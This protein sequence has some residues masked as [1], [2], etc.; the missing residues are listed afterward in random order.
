MLPVRRAEIKKERDRDQWSDLYKQTFDLLVQGRGEAL[1]EGIY[2]GAAYAQPPFFEF[3]AFRSGEQVQRPR[4]IGW[5]HPGAEIKKAPSGNTGQIDGW[6]ADGS[7]EHQWMW[8]DPEIVVWDQW[9]TESYQKISFEQNE[10]STSNDPRDWIFH[11]NWWVQQPNNNRWVITDEK[12]H[13]SQRGPRGQAS[14]KF[15][16]A[17]DQEVSGWLVPI[18]ANSQI[19][20]WD[21]PTNVGR[22][23]HYFLI[24]YAMEVNY[25][26]S[27]NHPQGPFYPEGGFNDPGAHSNPLIEGMDHEIW[28]YSD[29]DCIFEYWITFWHYDSYDPDIEAFYYEEVSEQKEI[30]VRGGKW[31]R[32]EWTVFY[33][34]RLNPGMPYPREEEPVDQGF[35]TL[36]DEAPLIEEGYW[37]TCRIRVKG[38]SA[39]QT[40]Y[41]DDFYPSTRVTP[42]IDPII[43][44]GVA[45]WIRDE[46]GAYVGADVWI[47]VS[48]APFVVTRN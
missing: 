38:G 25:S 30:N 13:V 40:V 46:A 48:E 31:E 42:A 26:N 15:T 18:N 14:A 39:G 32:L 43:T 22:D 8:S 27:Y 9:T 33:P 20:P 2:F 12:A 7:F 28:V 47:K 11:G 21:F 41:V 10:Y 44:V 23:I 16:F 3:S 1:V 5:S 37:G 34:P 6:I 29:Q 4:P 45:K 36:I 35:S 24:T 17:S 19:N